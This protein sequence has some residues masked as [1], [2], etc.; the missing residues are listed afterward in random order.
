V[1]P[2]LAG[3]DG[4]LAAGDAS[5]APIAMIC[6]CPGVV[7][8]RLAL[9][10]PRA[11]LEVAG[12]LMSA[13]VREPY[14]SVRLLVERFALALPRLYGLPDAPEDEEVWSPFAVCEELAK[15]RQWRLAR[16]SRP[17]AHRAGLQIISDAAS[18]VIPWCTTLGTRAYGKRIIDIEEK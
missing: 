5:A 10:V 7:F 11:M 6:D 4:E 17:D 16:S 12:S 3:E 1:R 2:A 9:E 8:P 13:Q 18:G 14:S 15:R